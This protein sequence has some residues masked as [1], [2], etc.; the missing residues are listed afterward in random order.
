MTNALFSILTLMCIPVFAVCIAILY[1]VSYVTGWS[2]EETSVYINIYL[3]GFLIAASSLFVFFGVLKSSKVKWYKLILSIAYVIA[4]FGFYAVILQHYGY[5]R[6][7]AFDKCYHELMDI[8]YEVVISCGL[9]DYGNGIDPSLIEYCAGPT[10]GVYMVINVLFFV[11]AF[12]TIIWL[13]YYI[14]KKCR[15]IK[16]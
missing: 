12:I 15:R 16:T 13:N 8:S 11:S 3:Q 5:D 9:S 10:M 4:N 2:Y 1:G 6:A 14:G 7:V